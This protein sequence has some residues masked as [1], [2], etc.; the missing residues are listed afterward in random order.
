MR[1]A[2]SAAL[3]VRDELILENVQL[4]KSLA[5]RLARRLPLQVS[6]EDLVSAGVLGLVDAAGRYKP[7]L[8]VPF[9]AFAR[10]RVQGAMLDALRGLDW[11]PRSLRRLRRSVDA[12]V[13][14]TRARLDREPEEHEIAAALNMDE[15]QYGRTMEELR[16]LELASVRE[17][18]APSA[19]GMALIDLCVDP[20][21]GP[22]QRLERQE[23]GRLLASAIG[24]LPERERQ[25][26]ALYYQEEL[27]L[28][29]IGEVIGVCESRVCQLRGLA[30]SRLR[31]LL[32]AALG[33]EARES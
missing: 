18:D 31:T 2:T 8:G 33:L 6:V 17:L 12:A 1:V 22:A 27:T 11:A 7:T 16:T 29:Q 13:A 23:L 32:R 5:Q 19:D 20:G 25:I 30:V 24:K 4:V 26:L 21:E 14:S 15:Q 9:Q 10:R 3:E 28:S